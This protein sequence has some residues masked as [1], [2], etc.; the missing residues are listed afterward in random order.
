MH[1][2]DVLIRKVEKTWT[3]SSR[4]RFTITAVE[5]SSGKKGMTLEDF[6]KKK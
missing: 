4:R 1:P 6:V 5:R 2:D 3:S